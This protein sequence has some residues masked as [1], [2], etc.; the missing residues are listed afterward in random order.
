MTPMRGRWG[1]WWGSLEGADLATLLRVASGAGFREVSCTP[2]MW[3]AAGGPDGDPAS[4][5]AL[6]DAHDVRVTMIDPLLRGLPGACDA[7]SVSPRW[8]STFEHDEDD[9][10]RVADALD[11]GLINVAHF[12]GAPTPLETLVDAI[13]GIT[14]RAA[15]RGRRI[16]IEAMPEGAIP[17]VATAASIVRAVAHPACGLT[18]D[19]WHW[20]RS[21]G[22][23]E[24]LRALPAGAVFALQMSDALASARGTGTAPPSRDRLPIGEGDLPIVALLAWAR[25]AHPAAHVGLEV[26]DRRAAGRAHE[27]VAAAAAA[28]VRRVEAALA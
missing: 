12:L 21:G 18:V 1:L 14:E 24:E 15:A 11:A 26:F 16:A 17:D 3:F 28:S 10:H 20:W 2:A 9:C 8:R 7:A 27:V 5:R 13:G 6:L 19:T 23:L 22:D 4:I 25:E